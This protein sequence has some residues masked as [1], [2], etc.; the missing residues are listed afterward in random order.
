MN[1]YECL[2]AKYIDHVRQSEGIDF[3]HNLNSPEGSDVKFT[4][5]DIRTLN[6]LASPHAGK[7]CGQR[8]ATGQYWSFCGETDMGQTAPALCTECGGKYKLYE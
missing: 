5:S 4:D 3:L 6:R 7:G 8:L 1:D 2:L